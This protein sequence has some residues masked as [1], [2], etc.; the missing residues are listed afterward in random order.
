MQHG[1]KAEIAH[2]VPITDDRWLEQ[3]QAHAVY[4]VCLPR[5]NQVPWRRL[6]AV[7]HAHS[8]QIVNAESRHLLLSDAFVVRVQNPQ[9]CLLTEK[10]VQAAWVAPRELVRLHHRQSPP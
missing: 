4:L 6:F 8:P 5:A 2:R 1:S 9:N 7:W 10:S 3:T